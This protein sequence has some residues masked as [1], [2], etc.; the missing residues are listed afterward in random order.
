MVEARGA[1]VLGLAL[2]LPCLQKTQVGAALAQAFDGVWAGAS[3]VRRPSPEGGQRLLAGLLAL[4]EE[5]VQPRAVASG[6]AAQSWL[7][8]V[9]AELLRAAPGGALAQGGA[10]SALVAQ[11]LRCIR[12]GALGDLSL[13]DVAQAVSRSPN[14]VATVIKAETG[15][16]VGQW[17]TSVKMAHVRQWLLH[18]QDSL[19]GIAERAGFYSTSHFYKVFRRF[20]GT[21]PARWRRQHQAAY[22]D[23]NA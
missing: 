8:V 20:H 3:P 23:T 4:E 6:L 2:C 21:T 13:R 15:H 5:L 12:E 18:S 22:A 14:H 11:A 9:T 1:Q 19:E 16:T 10:Q 17:I 7:G